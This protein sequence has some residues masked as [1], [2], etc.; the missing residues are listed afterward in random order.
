MSRINA[1]G[2]LDGPHQHG[3]KARHSTTSAILDVQKEIVRR[4]DNDQDCMVHSVDLSAAF[5]MLRK[6][7]LMKDLI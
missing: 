4:L 7:T 1:R 3:L 6:N 2:E 5:D